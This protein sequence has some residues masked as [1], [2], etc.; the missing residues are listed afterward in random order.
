MD[1]ME[2]FGDFE[3]KSRPAPKKVYKVSQVNRYVKQLLARDV[4]LTRLWVGGEISNFK[5]HSSGHLYFTL[6]DPGGAISAV[7]FASDASGLAFRPRDGMEVA[8]FGYISL[9]EKTGQ[10][11]LYVQKLEQEGQGTLFEA[12]EALKRKL[13]AEGLFDV[14]RKR[15]IPRYPRTIGIVTSPTGAAVR[16]IIQIARRR[17]PGISLIL[18]PVLV[19]GA[20]AAASICS[21]IRRM[22]EREDVDL[23]IVGRGGG[24]L[25]DLWAFNEEKVA[26]AIAGSR[27][28]IIS[29]VG[30]ET[31]FTIADFVSDLRAPTPS[32]AA[33]LAAPD[34]AATLDAAAQRGLYLKQLALRQLR[35]KRE[36]ADSIGRR[37]AFRMPRMKLNQ[38]RQ[39]IDAVGSDMEWLRKQYFEQVRQKL[40]QTEVKLSLLSPEHQLKK[41]YAMLTDEEGRLIDS[42]E[43]AQSGDTLTVQL[44]D[45]SIGVRVLSREREISKTPKLNGGQHETVDI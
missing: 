15:P 3:Q 7:M 31:D 23:C 27:I 42:I 4:I 14:S 12:F 20:G 26:R 25:E 29:A 13:E 1:Q 24:S 2:L 45:G 44:H 8:A 32:A 41:G 37:A 9:Y 10:Y 6:K 34:I 39:Q 11:Q 21:G 35:R 5:R 33:E 18:C 40:L 17:H 38:L 28:P 22:N 36:T 43:K 19:Q 16:D 30:H